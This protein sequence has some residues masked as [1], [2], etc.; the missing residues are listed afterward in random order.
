MAS[1]SGETTWERRGAARLERVDGAAPT[2]ATRLDRLHARL[3]EGATAQ[4]AAVLEAARERVGRIAAAGG[5]SEASDAVSSCVFAADVIAGLAAEGMLDPEEP[6]LV[7]AALADTCSTPLQAVSFDLFMR[8]TTS[9][10]LLSLPP[11]V[12]AEIQLRLLQQLS[13]ASEVSLWRRTSGGE[14]ELVLALSISSNDPRV[15][16]E[17]SA[18]IFGRPRM[19]V[20]RRSELLSAQVERFGV[21]KAAVVIRPLA[22]AQRSA[23]GYLEVVT[24]ALTPLLDREFLLEQGARRL[25]VLTAGA[26]NRVTQLGFDLHDGPVQDVLALGA[27]TRRLRDDASPFVQESHRELVAGRFDD[28]LA[29]I[30]DLDRQLRETAH[31]LESSSVVSRPLAEVLHREVE[32]FERRTSIS[33]SIEVRGD[34]ETLSPAQRLAIYRATQEALTNVREHSGATAV[35]VRLRVRRAAVHVRVTD[36]GHGFE[37]SRALAL[38]AERGRL[39]L[40]GID[41][42][43]RVLGGSFAIDSRPGGPTTLRFSLPRWEPFLLEPGTRR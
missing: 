32:A 8:T 37:V 21:P 22:E 23:H 9:P 17:A 7:A 4:T 34:P 1:L 26:E 31:S 14:V 5:E 40:V 6:R 43:M 41:E 20:G 28:L 33:A 36:D 24:A 42:R 10:L 30:E 29:R 38:A 27:E 12:A 39:G 15:R 2:R 18:A 16:Q 3:A 11:I 13:V 19:V 35:E 25:Q